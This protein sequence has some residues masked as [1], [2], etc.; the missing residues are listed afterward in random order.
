MYI[1]IISCCFF[2]ASYVNPS[3]YRLNV[4]NKKNFT[5]KRKFLISYVWFTYRHVHLGKKV[6][7]H[8][9]YQSAVTVIYTA[10]ILPAYPCP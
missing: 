9:Y 6:V 7:A 10:N 3:S 2:F 4:R 8:T 1:N 5:L